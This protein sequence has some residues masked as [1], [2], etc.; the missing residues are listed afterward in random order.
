[1]SRCYSRFVYRLCAPY[2][3]DLEQELETAQAQ[4]PQLYPRHGGLEAS[5]LLCR[6][7]VCGSGATR[8]VLITQVCPASSVTGGVKEAKSRRIP[9]GKYLH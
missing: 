9:T 5:E 7:E 6:G 2:S 3:H 4:R 1:M 8:D